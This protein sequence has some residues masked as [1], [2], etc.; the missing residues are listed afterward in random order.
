MLQSARCARRRG[1]PKSA[2]KIAQKMD[3]LD[4]WTLKSPSR[5]IKTHCRPPVRK[6]SVAPRSVRVPPEA[7][8]YP[9]PV[10][11]RYSSVD[12][13][14]PRYPTPAPRSASPGLGGGDASPLRKRSRKGAAKRQ[15][16]AKKG[17]RPLH[18]TLC[19]KKRCSRGSGQLQE[20]PTLQGRL[21]ASRPEKQK[22][23]KQREKN[24][25]NENSRAK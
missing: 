23:K 8:R 1:R 6:R 21:A 4:F 12:T 16:A 14:R 3:P 15:P 17:L 18:F 13:P 19:P 11:L 22:K 25:G 10:G 24:A 5:W 9:T 7:S 20:G 2:P